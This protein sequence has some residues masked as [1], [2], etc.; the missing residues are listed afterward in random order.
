MVSEYEDKADSFGHS[1]CPDFNNSDIR[2]WCRLQML[3]RLLAA[4]QIGALPPLF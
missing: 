3:K 1:S 2:L 4:E